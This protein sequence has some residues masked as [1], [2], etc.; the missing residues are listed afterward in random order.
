MN[1]SPVNWLNL[2]T[3]EDRFLPHP[4]VAS[5]EPEEERQGFRF[6][7][8]SAVHVPERYKHDIKNGTEQNRRTASAACPTNSQNLE[9][10][11][12]GAQMLADTGSK[13]CLKSSPTLHFLALS[14]AYQ[15]EKTRDRQSCMRE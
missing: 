10:T 12:G 4:F 13:S 1:K 2:A 6:T 11:Y 14:F 9:D 15:G 3:K 5:F 7:I 8:C